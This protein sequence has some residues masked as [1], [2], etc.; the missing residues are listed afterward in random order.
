MLLIFGTFSIFAFMIRG[1][2][3]HNILYK[4]FDGD[5]KGINESEQL[6][7]NCPRCQQR[8]GL[9]YP[10]GKYNLE[11]NTAKRVFKCWKCEEPRFSG[12]LG[13]LIRIYGNNADYEL[14]K[15]YSSILG[16][17]GRYNEETDDVEIILPK[18]FI[19]FTDIDL[20]NSEHMKAYNY[21][22]FDR[23]I[24]REK[25][26]KYRLGFCV[27]G[28]YKKRI[29]IPSYD[30]NGDLNYFVSRAYDPKINP[31]Y[32]NPKKNKS[33]FIF[34]EGYIN[35]DKTVYIVEGAFDMLSLPSN[36][37]P[38]LGKNI[39][40]YLY[41]VLSEKKPNIVILLDPDAMQSAVSLFFMLSRIYDIGDERLKLIELNNNNDIND[42]MKNKGDN[43]VADILRTARTLTIDD[44]FI[45]NLNNY[46]YGRYK[47]YRK[48]SE[49]G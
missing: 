39:F 48:Y 38:L 28:R 46:E 15:S 43:G 32:L 42:I 9:S 3:F 13:K 1:I 29:I 20:N 31:K 24:P 23:K 26:L 14:Y 44:Y 41:E 36:A 8:D 16:D 6:K 11:I 18:E 25:I 30:K 33:F 7:V 22:I 5:V 49:W 4:I 37:I 35:W 19:P 34:N 10:D 17:Y 12:N 2:E 47:N 27:E 40:D 21:L 45:T